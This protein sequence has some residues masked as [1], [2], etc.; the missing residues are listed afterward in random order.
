MAGPTGSPLTSEQERALASAPAQEL[1]SLPF[2]SADLITDPGQAYGVAKRANHLRVQAAST[3][4]GVRR[5][6]INSIS[7]GVIST[8]MGQQELAGEWPCCALASCS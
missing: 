2:L 1:L 5:A 7:P 8:P 3:A 4:W 6:R